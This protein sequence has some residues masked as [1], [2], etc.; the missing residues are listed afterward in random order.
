MLFANKVYHCGEKYKHI[1]DKMKQFMFDEPHVSHLIESYR[2]SAFSSFSLMNSDEDF[3]ASYKDLIRKV[4]LIQWLDLNVL[5]KAKSKEA[6]MG[7]DKG[8]Q[9]KMNLLAQVKT[10][11]FERFTS[12]V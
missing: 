2:S 10:T 11:K 4:A 7:E 12:E 6:N 5:L 8:E 1:I 3:L 9:V